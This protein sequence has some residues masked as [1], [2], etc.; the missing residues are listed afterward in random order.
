MKMQHEKAPSGQPGAS[1]AG[2]SNLARDQYTANPWNS[3][4]YRLDD[5]GLALWAQQC[6]RFIALAHEDTDDLIVAKNTKD[7][8]SLILEAIRD[9]QGKRDRANYQMHR[10]DRGIPRRILD[11]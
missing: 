3:E 11:D 4:A 7:L 9:E 1:S 6:E 10:S 5:E 2:R 8:A